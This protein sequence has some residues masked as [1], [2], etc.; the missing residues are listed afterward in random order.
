MSQPCPIPKCIRTSRGLCDC[1]KQ[2]LCLQHLNEHNAALI[3]QLNP[4]T[5]EINALGDR[6]KTLNIQ[7]T[8]GHCRQKLEQWRLDCHQ[9]IDSFFEQKCQEVDRL[10]DKK[11]GKKREEIIQIQ[12]KMAELVR[13]QETTREEINSLTTSIHYLEEN[14]NNIEQTCLQIHT[15]SVMIDDSLIDIEEMNVQEIHISTLPS[16]YKTIKCLD[17]SVRSLASND[18][19]LLIYDESNLCLFDREI[20]KV[21]QV[22]WPYGKIYDMC[23]SS[24]LNQFIVIGELD[25]L[26]VDENTMSID[27]I[28][29]TKQLKY[30]SCT[31]SDAFLFL[32][33]RTYGL[34]IIALTLMSSIKLVKQ[35]KH[36]DTCAI[37][38]CI[39]GIA[40]NKETLGLMVMNKSNK[41]I[42]I[43]L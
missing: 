18:R 6:L 20:N 5:D 11:V 29:T 41:S 32:S 10:I 39:N 3:S 9:K 42:R 27:S 34:S 4:L 37:D 24:I 23:W 1:C 19:F 35:W 14:M 13:A 26:L 33:T 12:S 31:C 43:E 36:P 21:K 16:L 28:Q 15:R 25:V 17:I 7:K 8:A 38:E 30:V 22:T 2:H 40:H